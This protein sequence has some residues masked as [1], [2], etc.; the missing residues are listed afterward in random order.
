MAGEDLV[1]PSLQVC[2]PCVYLAF[3]S[4]RRPVHRNYE[5]ERRRESYRFDPADSH[6][7]VTV[8]KVGSAR[9][10]GH[11]AGRGM[12]QL[13]SRTTAHCGHMNVMHMMK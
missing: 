5:A 6:P 8:V 9:V 13:D 12:A 4:L 1:L 7:L 11:L 3:V 10:Q 2:T